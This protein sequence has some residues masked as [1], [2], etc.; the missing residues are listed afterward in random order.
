MSDCCETKTPDYRKQMYEVQRYYDA[1]A[2]DKVS[3]FSPQAPTVKILDLIKSQRPQRI[4]DIGCGNGNTLFN[5]MDEPFVDMA[6]GIDFSWNM[7][8]QAR[9]TLAR[10]K[11]AKV[12]FFVGNAMNIQYPHHTFDA[13]ISECVFNLLPDRKQGLSE[14]RRLLALDGRAYLSDFVMMR[15][16][17][18]PLPDGVLS[19]VSACRVG[20]LS[21]PDTL[22]AFEQAGL[23]VLESYDFT[24]E[25]N[26]YY[27]RY[28]SAL[29]ERTRR[30][31]TLEDYVGY[32]LFVLTQA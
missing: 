29:D 28:H 26:E 12:A 30:E 25:K 4:L 11:N 31:R 9:K 3:R 5:L 16:F 17:P 14:V 8:R 27:A 22:R 1:V 18:N 20:S 2:E 6:I 32:Y 7:I 10:T 21:V 23:A 19:D 24:Q 15:P 13:I